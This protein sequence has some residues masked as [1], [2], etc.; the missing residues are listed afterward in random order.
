MAKDDSQDERRK[1][2][3]D[4][5]EAAKMNVID[6]NHICFSYNFDGRDRQVLEDISVSVE[7]GD[8]AAVLTTVL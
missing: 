3:D 1:V 6:G 7:K 2:L 8:F 5:K 4:G